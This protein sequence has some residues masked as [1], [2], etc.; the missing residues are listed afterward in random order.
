MSND[1]L[2]DLAAGAW[3]GAV[4]A[5]WMAHTAV[6]S[7]GPTGAAA[8]ALRAWSGIWA[9]LIFAVAVLIATG[10]L[11]LRYRAMGVRAEALP[12]RTRIA[13]T[14]HIVFVVVLVAA[15]VAAFVLFSS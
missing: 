6:K 12:A 15:T 1:L 10:S 9:I 5:L 11:R 8:L 2:H 13:V 4:I 14:K 7:A 3:P